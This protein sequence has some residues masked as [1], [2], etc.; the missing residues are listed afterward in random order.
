[1]TT[2][3]KL[4][5]K[6]RKSLKEVDPLTR[7]INKLLRK[8][9]AIMK[10]ADTIHGAMESYPDNVLDNEMNPKVLDLDRDL[11]DSVVVLVDAAKSLTYVLSN[12]S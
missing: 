5:V 2:N 12:E 6:I 9:Q 1:M 3:K 8:S 10:R 4:A 11:W 7:D